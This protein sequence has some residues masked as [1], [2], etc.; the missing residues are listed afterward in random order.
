MTLVKKCRHGSGLSGRAK[1]DAWHACGCQWTAD[2]SIA[3][4]RVYRPLGTEYQ[5]ARREHARL[6][7]DLEHG[8]VPKVEE[9]GVTFNDVADRYWMAAE[10]RLAPNTIGGYRSSLNHAR[11]ALGS[12]D[13]RSIGP[14]DLDDMEAALLRSGY[15]DG[16]VKLV[17]TLTGLV[18]A[19]AGAEGLI[20]EPPRPTPGRTVQPSDEP[21][22]LP[23][24]R[25]EDVLRQMA[26]VFARLTRFTFMTGLRPGEAIAVHH[27]D[28][29]GNVVHVHRNRIQRTGDFGPTKTRAARFVDVSPLALG[30][31]EENTEPVVFPVAYT[32]WL[33]AWHDA[34]EL[35]GV[36]RHGLHTL[37][38]S[39]VA[40]RLISGQPITYVSRQL[41]HSSSAFTLRRY[42]RWVPSERDDAANLDRVV[43][44]SLRAT[45][46]G[47]VP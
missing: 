4:H 43:E 14:A 39:N 41:G 18:L 9:E 25:M 19:R 20:G 35:A 24:E 5:R 8:I 30:C 45:P 7:G 29:T 1:M 3:G 2:L 36:D 16:T 23:P 34:L 26:G 32:A 17:R 22:A 27:E 10:P 42:G 37:R 21:F 11:N 12:L 40:M 46:R 38:H 15:A 47:R 13:V 6:V 33:R 31:V 28:I 44:Q